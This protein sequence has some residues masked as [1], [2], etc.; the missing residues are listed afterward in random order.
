MVYETRVTV[1][2]HKTWQVTDTFCYTETY[3]THLIIDRDI[4]NWRTLLYQDVSNTPDHW[5]GYLSLTNFTISWRIEHTWS[6]A[7]ISVTDELYYIMTYRTHLNIGSDI[8]HRRTLL[9]QDVSNAPGHWQGYLSL[10]NFTISWRIEHTWSLAGIS[11]TDELYYIMTYRTHLI[12]GRDICHWRTL[13]YHDV[14]N[15]SE[16]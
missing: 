16:H 6:L 8:C 5:Q 9:Y 13:L 10:T 15:A 12:I 3:R 2:I 1:K 4:C 11:V 14:S 7:G